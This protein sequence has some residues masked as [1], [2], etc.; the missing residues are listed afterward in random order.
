MSLP[1]YALAASLATLLTATAA[2]NAQEKQGKEAHVLPALEVTDEA[3]ERAPGTTEGTG[4][5]AVDSVSTA[6]KFELAPREIPQSVSVV[7]RTQIE[8][9]AL[10]DINDALETTT[11][12]TVEQVETDRTYYT[13]RGFDITTFQF[14]GIGVPQPYGVIDGDID[15]AIY[16]SVVIVRGATGLV[17]PTGDPSAV[18]NF[19]R[20][21]PTREAQAEVEL[22]AGSWDKRRVEADVSGP[23]AERLRGRLVVAHQDADSYLDRYS[24]EKTVFYG[25]LEADLAD[26]TTLTLGHARQDNE[27]DSPL[28]GAPPLFY[29]DGTPTD[30][31][32]STSTAAEWAYW[33]GERESTFL[34]L[35]H[36]FGNGWEA[37]A[38]ASRKEFTENSKLFY[39]YGT[40]DLST[41]GS[42]LFAFPSRYDSNTEQ[43]IVDLYATGPFTL[44]GRTHQLMAGAGWSKSE[45]TDVSNFGQGIGTEIPQD[46]VFSGTYPEPT[47]DAF[48][49]GSN[50]T[51]KQVSVYS[52]ARLSVTDSL[53]TILGARVSNIDSEGES[54]GVSRATSYDN[55][56]VPYAGVIYDVS[57]RHSVYAS[58]T[59]VFNPQ[60]QTD[61]SGNRLDPV[62][63]VN[64][65]AG[66][67]SQLFAGLNTAFAIFKTEQSNVAEPDPA[68]A[69]GDTR[70]RGVD[71]L[72]AEGFEIDLA[73]EVLPGLQLSAGYTY[74]DIENADGSAAR[75][76]IPRHLVRTTASYRLQ[77]LPKLKV[78]ARVNWQD[79]TYVQTATARVEQDAFALVGLMARY[80]FTDNWSANLNIN[81]VT[82]EKYYASLRW[83]DNTGQGFYAAPRN[84]SVTLRW[85]Y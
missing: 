26:N 81:N 20:K 23:L 57:K 46:Q 17:S 84:A 37:R 70:F 31:D 69:P 13:A 49:M 39:V 52:A 64:Y 67:K 79:D 75:T 77:S 28:W 5:Y 36:R 1:R 53:T 73:G 62:E 40:P 33:D 42:D 78:G 12:V 60:T 82:D 54:Y 10:D 4:S 14:D 80:D 27:A 43:T 25:V 29:T 71:G 61:L 55:E 11:G 16:D 63:G 6:T 47:F 2:A 65:E 85:Q 83:A 45:L 35:A 32:V 41:P 8:D 30:Y 3:P 15:T 68:S 22:T 9:F 24:H 38:I 21:R 7:T 66:I 50:F 44:A 19:V 58:Y 34:E 74:L 59:E 51:D 72:T 18:I 48:T 56:V 76:Y